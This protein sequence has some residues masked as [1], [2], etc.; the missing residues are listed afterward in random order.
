MKKTVSIIIAAASLLVAICSCSDKTAS[1]F[2]FPA[3]TA[4]RGCWLENL[5]P[6]NSI[7][8]VYMAKRFGYPAI[9]CDVKYTLD[10]VMVLMHDKTI[11]R[12]MRNAADYSEIAEPVVVTETLFKD[13]REKYVFASDDPKERVQIPT[14][15]EH[16]N[17]C[18]ECGIH[19]VLHSEVEESYRL[20]KQILGDDFT[21]FT[22]RYDK[23]SYARTISS[24][25]ILWD[26]GKAPAEE[27]V[28][29]LAE[30][31]GACGM[32]TMKWDMLD[33]EYI[34][35]IKEAGYSVQSS[36]FKTPHEADAIS[37]GA[38]FIL[39][40]F[41]WFQQEGRTADFTWKQKKNSFAA[42]ETLSYVHPDT[43]DYGAMTLLLDFEGEIEVVVNG[44]RTYEFNS[45]D[46]ATRAIGFRFSRTKPEISITAVKDSKIKKALLDIYSI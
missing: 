4:H 27:T 42:G 9:E 6:E 41:C 8:G 38:T 18:K 23:V 20:A 45:E 44:N 26:P 2:A 24:C 35:K 36:I 32:S 43:M 10:S 33:A 46:Y 21:A 11:N 31:G 13:L 15:E 37:D 12:T 17:A 34:A 16:L 30:I 22:V 19:P 29:K 3:V 5:V 7:S 25:P 28:A 1:E 40:D 14:L 39:S